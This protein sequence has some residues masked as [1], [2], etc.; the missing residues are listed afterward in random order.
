MEIQDFLDVNVLI[1]VVDN[2]QEVL[3][4]LQLV[5]FVP[6]FPLGGVVKGVVMQRGSV[7]GIEH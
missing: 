6:P 3:H 5:N 4:V 1:A 2:N 7:P